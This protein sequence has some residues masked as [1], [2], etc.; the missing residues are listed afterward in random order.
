MF[1]DLCIRQNIDFWQ[2]G[3][4][5]RQGGLDVRQGGL[6]FRQGGHEFQSENNKIGA[7]C[8]AKDDS[9]PKP[10]NKVKAMPREAIS[11]EKKNHRTW[12]PVGKVK[13]KIYE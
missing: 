8:G 9:C 7:K 11:E 10:R 6:D 1:P 3:L 13:G 5:V 4:D 12:Q 2:G